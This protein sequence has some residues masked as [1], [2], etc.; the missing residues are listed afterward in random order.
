MGE[1]LKIGELMDLWAAS[2][3][4]RKYDLDGIELFSSKMRRAAA[5]HWA[6][7]AH[8]RS[9]PQAKEDAE[10]RRAKQ[11]EAWLKE[12]QAEL[13]TTYQTE[14]PG[15]F[16]R[17]EVGPYEF[18]PLA[19]LKESPGVG[20]AREWWASDSPLLFMGG[21]SQ[22]GKTTA[23]VVAMQLA[24]TLESPAESVP[25]P[26]WEPAYALMVKAYELPRLSLYEKA[27]VRR[28]ERMKRVRLLVLDDLGVEI[29][30]DTVT[31]L[32]TE[33]VEGRLRQFEKET[34]PRRL[35]TI[36]TT[37][38]A[39]KDVLERYGARVYNRL[40]GQSGKMVG[41]LPWS[42]EAVRP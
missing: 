4:E 30:S 20:A 9:S 23:A 26:I 40:R 13:L 7:E 11:R 14:L 18:Q 28:W 37:N 36:I 25:G 31:M 15:A 22:Y 12:R 16:G 42:M 29:R 8:E 24:A 1:P 33:L 10:V 21:K 38:L 32:V 35:R 34:G 27:D 41:I 6:Q 39:S 17:M 3:P 2:L 19:D 5:A